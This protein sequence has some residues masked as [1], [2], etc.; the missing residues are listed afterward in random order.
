MKEYIC[1]IATIDEVERKWNYEIRRQ[2]QRKTVLEK[3]KNDAVYQIK[4]GQSVKYY[5]KL[6]NKIICETTA[7]FDENI[8]QNSDELVDDKIVYLCNFSTDKRYRG[9][10]YFSKLFRFMIDDLKNRGYEKFTLGVEPTET[11]NLQIYQHL[12]FNNFIKS[13]RETYPDGTVIDVDYYEIHLII[14]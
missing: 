5:G 9:K 3:L 10:G 4:N 11:K 7:I 1:K 6:N 2:K 8:I 13:G 12:G 14:T